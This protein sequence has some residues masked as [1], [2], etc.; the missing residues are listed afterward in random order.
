MLWKKL[1]PLQRT[2]AVP[3]LLELVA[4]S[5]VVASRQ[6]QERAAAQACLYLKPPVERFG[7]M[8]FDAYED[9]YRVGYDY[10]RKQLEGWSPP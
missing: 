3:G 10:A 7:T 6:S 1:N 9:L 2:V 5:T 8:Q 4:Q